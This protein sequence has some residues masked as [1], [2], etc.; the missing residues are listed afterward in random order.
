MESISK[1]WEE[2]HHGREWGKYPSEPVI[3][4]VARN[5]YALNRG[6]VKILD[7][8]CGQGAH[9]WY[10]AREGFDVYAFDGSAS[11][12]EKAQEYLLHE[13][14]N[15]K[16]SVMDGINVKYQSDFFDAV[17]DNACVGHN[18]L[19]N[20]KAMYSEIYRILKYNGKLFTSFFSTKTTGFGTGEQI[21][22]NTYN[23]IMT[24]PLEGL[25]IVHFWD[26]GELKEVINN[27]GFSNIE[28]EKTTYTSHGT[29]ID[30]FI[31]SAVKV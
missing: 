29:L 13:N 30:C 26:E 8:G 21:E 3:R 6:E 19:E 12:V 1:E 16:F 2:I 28:I 7:F 4:F 31:L 11:A 22:K 18:K 24:G 14:L 17:I 10:L 9:T 5:F 20:I 15:A 25:G 23:N 27:A